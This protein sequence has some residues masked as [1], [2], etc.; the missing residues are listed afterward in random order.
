MGPMIQKAS[1]ILAAWI[2]CGPALESAPTI[3]LPLPPPVEGGG[4]ETL[5][6]GGRGQGEGEM[7]RT[8]KRSMQFYL[9][10]LS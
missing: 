7:D 4:I 3:T 9:L 2:P 10:Y 1:R 6:P 8:H 5:S